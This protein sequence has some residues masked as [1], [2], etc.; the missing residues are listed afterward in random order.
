MSP[1]EV[2][3]DTKLG[4]LRFERPS[5][6]VA[7]SYTT[8]EAPDSC[9]KQPGPVAGPFKARLG[10]GS[11]VTYYWYRFADQPAL[12]NAGLTKDEREQLQ[13]RVEMIHRSWPKDRDYLAP[14][15]AGT[16]V[17]LDPALLV[18]PPKGKEAGY[19]PIAT[20]QEWGGSATQARGH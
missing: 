6:P 15:T 20:R 14:P 18:I 7:E 2:P 16:L 9:W 8:P 5:E 12:L 4:S 10:D 3:A 1:K 19:V 17:E 13:N 11:V